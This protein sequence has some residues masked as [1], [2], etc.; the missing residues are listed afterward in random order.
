VTNDME[1][2][3]VR[4][5][6]FIEERRQAGRESYGA[7]LASADDLVPRFITLGG[8]PFSLIAHDAGVQFTPVGCDTGH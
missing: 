3:D 7:I 8:K 2:S 6:A 1:D 4:R 5:A